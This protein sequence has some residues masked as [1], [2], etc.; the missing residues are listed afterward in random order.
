[1][2]TNASDVGMNGYQET[3]KNIPWFAQNVRALIG[4]S[5]EKRRSNLNKKAC[6]CFL[7]EFFVDMGQKF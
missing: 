1:M 7:L 5:H 6:M 4:I 3:R 2:G